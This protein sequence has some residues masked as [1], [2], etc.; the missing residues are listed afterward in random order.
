MS[1]KTYIDPLNA[2]NVNISDDVIGVI[3]SIAASEIEGIAGMHG[4]LDITSMFGKKNKSKGVK[5]QIEDNEVVIELS[6]VVD[7]GVNISETA[8]KVQENVKNAVESMT[9]LVVKQVDINVQG[10]N[11]KKETKEVNEEID[12]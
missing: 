2:G 3:T 8:E 10:I 12:E 4:S 11:I 6:V 1:E 5:V 7:Y 9:S